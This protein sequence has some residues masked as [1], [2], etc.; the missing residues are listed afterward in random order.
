MAFVK[1]LGCA[2]VTGLV[3]WRRFFPSF[4]G[5]LGILASRPLTLAAFGGHWPVAGVH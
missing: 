1:C 5:F 3:P 2:A 4:S